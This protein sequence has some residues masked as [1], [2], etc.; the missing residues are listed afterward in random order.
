MPR[1]IVELINSDRFDSRLYDICAE[2]TESDFADLCDQLNNVN[3]EA[4]AKVAF[5]KVAVIIYKLDGSID[6][7]TTYYNL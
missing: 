6:F 1:T 5:E 3:S 4:T 7:E 2:S